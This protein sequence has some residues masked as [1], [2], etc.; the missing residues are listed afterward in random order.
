MYPPSKTKKTKN[1]PLTE[2][3]RLIMKIPVPTPRYTPMNYWSE[4]PAPFTI[5]HKAYGH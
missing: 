5:N 2:A 1:P 4:S 3:I